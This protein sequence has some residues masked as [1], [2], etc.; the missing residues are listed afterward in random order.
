MPKRRAPRVAMSRRLRARRLHEARAPFP[1]TPAAARRRRLSAR[2]NS[3]ARAKSAPAEL[4][5][6]PSQA[7][8]PVTLRGHRRLRRETIPT[9]AAVVPACQSWG[10][11]FFITTG[12][13]IYPLCDA[14][15]T[16]ATSRVL[17]VLHRSYHRLRPLQRGNPL[18]VARNHDWETPGLV[19]YPPT[20]PCPT[21]V[22]TTTSTSCL[23]HLFALD[24]DHRE[25]DGT[26]PASGSRPSGSTIASR[27]RPL[28]TTV[29]V[30]PPILRPLRG[31]TLR[32]EHALAVAAWCAEV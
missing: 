15:S 27:N 28:A 18:A 31:R 26:D 5:P 20:S 29:R 17:R 22:A 6:P 14:A 4:P 3:R 25:P 8:C 13:N 24:S 11:D 30:L 7:T 19:P 23:V 21:T 12:D 16:I 2:A 1:S 10:P 9:K 32:L